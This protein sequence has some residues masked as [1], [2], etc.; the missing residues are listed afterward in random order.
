MKPFSEA[1]ERNQQPIFEYLQ[2]LLA[3][4]KHVLEIGSG[5][6]QHAVYFAERLKHLVWQTSDVSENLSGINVWLEDA[7][8]INTPKPLLLDL[9]HQVKLDNGYDTVFSANTLHIIS[10]EQVSKF[11]ELAGQILSSQAKLIIYGPFNYN[12]EFTSESNAKFELWLK[13]RD[14]KSG[15]RD[16]EMV[17]GSADRNGFELMHDFTMPANNRLLVWSKLRL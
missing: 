14:A 5:T 9:D 13:Q 6:G 11:F 4:S 2:D 3:S 10:E 12:G 1:C 15:I 8:L 16:F 17:C 7:N